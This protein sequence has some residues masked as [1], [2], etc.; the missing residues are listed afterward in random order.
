MLIKKLLVG[1]WPVR[2][3]KIGK[4]GTVCLILLN[5]FACSSDDDDLIGNWVTL[6]QVEPN[7]RYDAVSASYDNIGYFGT[8]YDDDDRYNDFWSYDPVKNSYTQLP[9]FIGTP[10]LGA[11]AFACAGK[12]YIGTGNDNSTKYGLNDFYEYDIAAGSWTQIADFPGTARY[13]AVA[14]SINDVGYVGT[15][16]DGNYK[17]DFYKYDPATTEWTKVTALEGS[18]RY[19]AVAFVID[20]IAYVCTGLN[21][22]S[23]VNDFWKYDG[24]ADDWI[25]LRNIA[26]TNDDESYDDDYDIKRSEAVAFVADGKGYVCTGGQGSAGSD[27]WEYD[28]ATDLWD[29]KTGF[30]GASR[31]GAVAFSLNNI[32]YVLLGRNGSYYDSDIWYFQPN[33]EQDDDDNGNY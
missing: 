12:I 31:K 6:Y 10:R 33:A 20:N 24:V 17:K 14:F 25:Q 19:E 9:D 32:G 16:Y 8:G 22:S 13:G 1:H 3:M 30:E 11:V 7:A 4:V 28:P 21:S 29:E 26:D 27:T 5:L 23:Y 18:S 2:L 15:G